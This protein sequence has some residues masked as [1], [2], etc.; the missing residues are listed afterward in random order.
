MKRLRRLQLTTALLAAGMLAT[1]CAGSQKLGGKPPDAH[2]QPTSVP[3]PRAAPIAPVATFEG[4][5]VAAE[6]PLEIKRLIDGVRRLHEQPGLILDREAIYKTLGV[7]PTS[8]S[9][10]PRTDG[11][12]MTEGLGFERPQEYSNWKASLKYSE[13]PQTDSWSVRVELSYGDGTNCYPSRLVESYWG[14]P[15]VYRA[16]SV[17]AFLGELER[18]Q[19]DI[20]PTGPHDTAPYDAGFPSAA[21]D[22][23]NVIFAIG[24]GGCLHSI[25]ASKL[26]K[27][28]EYSDDHI[29]HQ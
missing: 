29:Y 25:L 15:F 20:P 24:F 4:R 7:K 18:K 11:R 13:F 17:R 28:K 27:L 3:L 2:N 21:A 10:P 23:A 16:I 19:V 9:E 26:F 1:A 22:T 14:K 12:R 8:L 5:P 6:L